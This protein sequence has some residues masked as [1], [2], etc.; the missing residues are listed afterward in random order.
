MS[1]VE[2][3]RPL[4]VLGIPGT[5]PQGKAEWSVRPDLFGALH[6]LEVRWSPDHVRVERTL[7]EPNGERAFMWALEAHLRPGHEKWAL[8]HKE[9]PLLDDIHRLT[10]ALNLAKKELKTWGTRPHIEE[11]GVP[12]EDEAVPASP[13]PS[14]TERARP[15]P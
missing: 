5:L 15:R 9:G 12:Y 2:S 4:R 11:N 1:P 14:V 6:S 3:P 13:S 8:T 7:V 10:D